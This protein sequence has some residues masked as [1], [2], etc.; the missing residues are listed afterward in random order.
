M[1]KLK[2]KNK[3]ENNA[4]L[5]QYPAKS[6]YAESYRTMRTNL[7]FA[8]M[9]R[10]LTVICVTSATEKEGK[11]NTVANLAYTIAQTG[12]H[13]LMVDCDLRKPGLTHRFGKKG[14]PG[15]SELVSEQLGTLM[16]EGSTAKIKLNDLVKLN[17]L[18]R[19]TGILSIADEE[20]SVELSFY[21][22]S[23][24]DVYWKNRP[25][26][27]KLASSLVAAN[28]L[29]KEQAQLAIG[30]Q[31]RSVQKLGTILTTMGMITM[32]DLKKHLSM[33]IV[34]AFKTAA[35]IYNG[36][37][38]FTPMPASQIDTTIE[39]DVN[40]EKMFQEFLDEGHQFPYL[41]DMIES[42]VTK[43]DVDNLYLMPSGKIPP[44][45]SEMVNSGKMAFALNHLSNVYDFVIIDTPPVLPAS[46]ALVL[47]PGTDGVLLVVKANQVNRKYIK[48][49]VKQLESVGTKI[50]G[51]VLNRVDVSRERYYRYYS[52]YYTSYYGEDAEE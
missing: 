27:K 24:T 23:L 11:T 48:D 10:D 7:Q 17:N 34:E 35:S 30:H 47:S 40:F 9:D 41:A 18:Q 39:H 14:E 5:D 29:T 25:D 3:E 19:R 16:A 38:K 46:D 8:S 12:Q 21:D 13:V 49:A 42:V 44:N 1:L 45:P 31:R 50:L 32:A 4:L 15:L 20:N 43:T 52:K 26:N 37:F 28:L 6:G 36:Q 22:G 33:H 2:K 51:V